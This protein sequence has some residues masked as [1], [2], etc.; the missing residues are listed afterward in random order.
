MG[1]NLFQLYRTQ[2]ASFTEV[3]EPKDFKT[4][5]FMPVTNEAVEMLP[6]CIWE[7]FTHCKTSMIDLVHT[8]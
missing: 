4:L 2:Q 6:I 8:F 3:S 1:E 7:Q 5:P